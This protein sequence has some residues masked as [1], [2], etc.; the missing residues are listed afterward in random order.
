MAVPKNKRYRQVVKTRRSLQ[1]LN[2]IT[3]KNLTISKFTNYVTPT[4]DYINSVRCSL[5]Q[6]EQ[7]TNKICANCYVDTFA[8]SFFIKKDN[9]NIKKKQK[10]KV[11]KYYAK[12]SKTLF[13]PR[14]P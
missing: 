9:K 6:N 7:I 3:K 10:F 1:K 2:L 12:L 11:N 13:P 14:R 5:C 4:I 8:R